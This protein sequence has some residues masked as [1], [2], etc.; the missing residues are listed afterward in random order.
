MPSLRFPASLGDR[1]F[2][3][4]GMARPVMAHR[5]WPAAAV[6]VGAVPLAASYA[7]GSPLHQLVTAL[8][9]APLFWACVCEDRLGR[10]ILL[11]GLVLGTH[12]ALAIALSATDPARAAAI[13]PGAAYYWGQTHHWVRT[14]DDPEYQWATWLPRHGVLFAAAV[15]CGALTLGL[16]ALARG[17]EQ[18][19]LMN[20]YVGRLAAQSDS[21]ALAVIFGWHPWSVLRGLAYTVL[22]FE[23]ASWVLAR[24]TGRPL[25]TPRRRTVR[26]AL[27]VGLA[28]ADGLAKF[29][30]APIVRDQLFANLRPDAI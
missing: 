29:Y 11:T 10:A 9:L 17:V 16:V 20:F 1:L 6:L 5:A 13:L 22:I 27:G 14:G 15:A 26:W 2:R 8:F 25:S 12:S 3:L 28:V 4:A 19:D 23:A 7:A 21:P 18:V 30:L 24:V